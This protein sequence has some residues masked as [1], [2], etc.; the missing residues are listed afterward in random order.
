MSMP[1]WNRRLKEYLGRSGKNRKQLSVET[2]IPYATIHGWL[3]DHRPPVH[4]IRNPTPRLLARKA[5]EEWSNGE[6]K[7]DLR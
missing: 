6:V 4:R 7:T 1:A 2:G 3:Y 5:I